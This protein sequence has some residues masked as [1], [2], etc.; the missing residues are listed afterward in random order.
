LKTDPVHASEAYLK[1]ENT[2]E[3]AILFNKTPFHEP[4]KQELLDCIIPVFSYKM[5]NRIQALPIGNDFRFMLSK[6]C[7]DIFQNL[8]ATEIL[9][10]RGHNQN[11]HIDTNSVIGPD[12]DVKVCESDKVFAS[13]G[14]KDTLGSI[15]D[16]SDSSLRFYEKTTIV[17]SQYWGYGFFHF[18]LECVQRLVDVDYDILI[19][20][21][22]IHTNMNHHIAQQVL[23]LI[24]QDLKVISGSVRVQDL[25]IP[26]YTPCGGHKTPHHANKLASYFRQHLTYTE[27]KHLLVVNRLGT[28]HV[29]NHDFFVSALQ[30][31]YPNDE[32]KIHTGNELIQEQMQLFANSK[33]VIAPH[34]AGLSNIIVM[35]K[36]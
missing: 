20:G 5:S 9:V 10:F 3:H 4:Y 11:L 34:G 16:C 24:H 18:M 21:V 15:P 32:I 6:S 25:I 17:I 23:N 36:E 1:K 14:C 35:Q 2:I 30:Q 28:R 7:L 22:Y 12:G 27:K 33:L 26:P 29:E 19:S 13:I 31:Q 8:T